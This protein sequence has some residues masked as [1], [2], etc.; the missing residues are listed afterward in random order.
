MCSADH[1]FKCQVSNYDLC[2]NIQNKCDDVL[3]C[4]DLSDESV[5]EC[6]NC[7]D[8]PS[9]FTCTYRGLMVCWD[10][11]YQCDGYKQRCDDGNDQDPATQTLPCAKTAAPILQPTSVVMA[12]ITALMV[13]MNLTHMPHHHM[14]VTLTI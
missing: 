10:N 11:G 13:L 6:P 3:S 4:T 1:L 12:G 2:T 7:V 8:D 9:K 5:S 14:P